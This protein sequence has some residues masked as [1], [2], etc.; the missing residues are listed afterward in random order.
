MNLFLRPI[1]S[2][3]YP[4]HPDWDDPFSVVLPQFILNCKVKYYNNLWEQLWQLWF[5]FMCNHKMTTEKNVVVIMQKESHEYCHCSG[6]LTRCLW[7]GTHLLCYL[8]DNHVLSISKFSKYLLS[9]FF[10]SG[11]LLEATDI[12][13]NNRTRFFLQE[14]NIS[15]EYSTGLR[16]GDYI[17]LNKEGSKQTR[18]ILDNDKFH[19]EG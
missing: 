16:T 8:L 19:G 11:T 5:I 18:K 14:F 7:D 3:S 2:F 9:P 1:L 6:P 17:Q 15:F 12:K 4:S 10:W 13:V